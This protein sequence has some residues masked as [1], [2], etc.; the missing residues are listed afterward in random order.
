MWELTGVDA[1]IARALYVADVI[2]D[3]SQSG[4]RF[5]DVES[6]NAWSSIYPGKEELNVRRLSRW[7]DLVVGELLVKM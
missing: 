4:E 2:L 7:G 3:F 6:F 1:E 5:D